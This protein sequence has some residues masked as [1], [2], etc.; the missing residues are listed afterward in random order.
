[1]FESSSNL[2]EINNVYQQKSGRYI[3]VGKDNCGKG[4]LVAYK[5]DTEGGC[6][7]VDT[8]FNPLA[9]NC[10]S[11]YGR[12]PGHF[13]IGQTGLYTL[14][15]NNDDTI[16]VAYSDTTVKIIEITANGSGLAASFNSGSILDTTITPANAYAIRLAI[17]KNGKIIVAS[18]VGCHSV[19]VARY[20]TSG[21][22]DNCFNS[23]D[24]F[25]FAGRK[26][27][28]SGVT[29]TDLIITDEMT[30]NDKIILLGY[31][32]A[33]GNGRLF[34]ARLA[35]NG[36]LD[37]TWD[38]DPSGCDTAGLTTF[39]VAS[40]ASTQINSGSIFINGKIYAAGQATSDV[41][42]LIRIFGDNYIT[43]DEEQPFEV[44]PGIIDTTIDVVNHTG[45][46]N[47]SNYYFNCAL[48]NYCSKTLYIYPSGAMILGFSNG[49]NTKIVK[50]KADQSLDTCFGGGDGIVT[51][52]AMKNL[53]DLFVAD[54]TNSDSLIYLTGDDNDGSM[55][56]A[57]LSANGTVYL[58]SVPNTDPVMTFGSTIRRS[59]NSRTLIV[60]MA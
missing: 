15:I 44:L 22:F 56:A 19:S 36:T 52:C 27:G 30:G 60:I 18:S 41:A 35:T 13:V 34:A 7:A 46:L 6:L 53:K 42:L 2:V 23:G 55:V 28:S 12:N 37:S 29:L 57:Q 4:V 45:A 5:D 21:S 31:N 9:S 8:T 43:Q 48:S 39:N 49:S 50:L 47:F 51:I 26:L 59:T 25:Q 32:T 40:G 54:G 58:S 20:T 38:I 10:H 3:V 17:D 11:T 24:I 33:G 14:A 1:M 16:L